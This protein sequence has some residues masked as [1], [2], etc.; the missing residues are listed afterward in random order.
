MLRER[1][2][3]GS[4]LELQWSP[5]YPRSWSRVDGRRR[6]S[7]S[8]PQLPS[9]PPPPPP[10]SS[11]IAARSQITPGFRIQRSTAH[12]VADLLGRA[13]D[14]RLIHAHSASA[15]VIQLSNAEGSARSHIRPF[16]KRVAD[17]V[18]WTAFQ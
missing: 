16:R 9:T 4:I 14:L 1:F 5:T 12:V 2:N 6:C 15:T 8:H 3:V 7:D 11:S 13:M 10:P 18:L 17:K